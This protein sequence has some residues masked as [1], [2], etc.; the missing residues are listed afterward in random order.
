MNYCNIKKFDIA[1]GIGVRV[2]LFV[3]GCTHH[4]KGCL[5]CVEVCPVNALVK[6]EE[7]KYPNPEYSMEN[8]DM[9]QGDVEYEEDLS[10]MLT[11][12][13]DDGITHITHIFL[14]FGENSGKC[15]YSRITSEN[16][17]S[18]KNETLCLAF[19]NPEIYAQIEKAIEQVLTFASADES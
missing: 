13:T 16:S 10:Q 12:G 9:L 8:K 5:R 6:G 17:D 15:V 2:T 7:K 19:E 3:S 14:T 18:E 11:I 4:C 1:D